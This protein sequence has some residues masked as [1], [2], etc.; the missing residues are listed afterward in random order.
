MIFIH[1]NGGEH[2][3]KRKNFAHLKLTAKVDQIQ[4]VHHDVAR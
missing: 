1:Q 4:Y 2:I 3:K